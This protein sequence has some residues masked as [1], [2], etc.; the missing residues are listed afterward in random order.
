MMMISV[1]IIIIDHKS[2]D[3]SKTINAR[4]LLR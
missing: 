3:N 2:P 4:I 1:D